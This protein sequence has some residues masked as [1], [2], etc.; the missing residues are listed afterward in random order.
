MLVTLICEEKIFGVLLPEKARGQYWIEDETKEVLDKERKLIGIEEKSGVWKIIGNKKLRLYE[1]DHKVPVTEII[2]EEDK[3]YFVELASGRRGYI[4]TQPY[5]EECCTYRKYQI[6]SNVVINIG[7]DA[8]NAIVFENPF[9]S[10]VH[11]QL[12]LSGNRWTILDNKSK[13]GVYINETRLNVSTILNPG[14]VVYIMGMKMV[15]GDHFLAINN[16][17]GK[18]KINENILIPYKKKEEDYFEDIEETEFKTYYRS[19]QFS[20]KIKPLELTID[21]PTNA[22][23][24]DDTP[25]IL[26]L[27]PSLIM[28]VASF[29]TVL[30]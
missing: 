16:P 1:T 22:E 5:S 27:A 20:R 6:S 24:Q 14:D 26:T 3:M 11:A 17:D 30:N 25:M 7:K 13:N 2:L 4:F 29:A 23:I 10:A 9:V 19:P 21:A 8:D 28:G 15:V 12:S 18:V